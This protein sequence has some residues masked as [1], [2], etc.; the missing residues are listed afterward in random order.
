MDL[1]IFDSFVWSKADQENFKAFYAELEREISNNPQHVLSG[2]SVS[3]M[4][5]YLDSDGFL[6]LIYE[7]VE[8]GVVH[9]T[10]SIKSATSYPYYSRLSDEELTILNQK[11][12]YWGLMCN[13]KF[14]NHSLLYKDY[15]FG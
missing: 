9:F 4:A 13:L 3:L 7:A 12:P 10:F 1:E 11:Y 6:I 2:R 8:S 14:W 15:S 5:R